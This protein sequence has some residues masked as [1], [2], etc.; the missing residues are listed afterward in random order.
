MQGLHRREVL[1][2]QS[3]AALHD[4]ARQPNLPLPMPATSLTGGSR[5]G[6][7]AALSAIALV[8]AFTPAHAATQNAVA[9]CYEKCDRVVRACVES[10]G[11][12]RA[13]YEGNFSVQKCRSD[14]QFCKLDCRRQR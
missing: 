4:P 14:L 2:A 1:P 11:V 7:I 6:S 13:Q 8:L 5:Y 10:T 12:P 3:A 9:Q